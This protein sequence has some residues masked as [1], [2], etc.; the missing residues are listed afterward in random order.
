M[1]LRFFDRLDLMDAT[2]SEAGL[3]IDS[4]FAEDERHESVWTRFK[5][6]FDQ[7]PA[8]QD[9][10]SVPVGLGNQWI[11]D[12]DTASYA[13]PTESHWTAGTAEPLYKSAR[14]KPPQRESTLTY[15]LIALVVAVVIIGILTIFALSTR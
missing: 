9:F 14:R 4:H 2:K 15:W 12:M 11:R 10:E 3:W 7:D 13:T 1:L 6:E 5:I 8:S